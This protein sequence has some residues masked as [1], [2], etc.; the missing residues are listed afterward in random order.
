MSSLTAVLVL[1]AIHVV[2]GVL[3]VGAIVF[4]AAFLLPAVRAAGPAGG[5]TMQQIVGARRLPAWMAG[6]MALTILSGLSLY[7]HDSAGFRSAWLGSG[8]GRTFGL[9]GALAIAGGVYGMLV[10]APTA[11]RLAEL[12]AR[13][14]GANRA[15]A[16][17]EL[18]DIQRLQGRLGR[19]VLVVAVLFVLATL[20]MGVA[21]YVP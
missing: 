18:A 4:I 21:R 16:P 13:V 6:A 11:R 10:N 1:R 12:G 15:P 8:P 14:Q 9:G 3:W 7:W 17:E 2:V 5:A 19:A 20:C